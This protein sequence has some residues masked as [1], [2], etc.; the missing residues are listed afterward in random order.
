MYNY[1]VSI[2]I[3]PETIP[4]TSVSAAR[5]DIADVSQLTANFHTKKGKRGF[6][7]SG[8]NKAENQGSWLDG[9]FTFFEDSEKY[10][11]WVGTELSQ[12]DGTFLTPQTITITPAATGPIVLRFDR[13]AGEYAKLIT[14][15]ATV[16]T[17]Y[18][19]YFV[20]PEAIKDA[21]IT[22]TFTKW[23]RGNSA[24]KLLGVIGGMILTYTRNNFSKVE[25]SL[26]ITS[27]VIKFGVLAN[28][29]S[30]KVKDDGLLDSLND[31]KL[32]Q[33]GLPVKITKDDV[34]KDTFV[35]ST[36][37]GDELNSQWTIDFTDRLSYLEDE[38]FEGVNYKD[39]TL[40]EIIL[41][42]I[43]NAEFINCD[44]IDKIKI[45]NSFINTT[46]K[47][48]ALV[49]CCNVGMLYITMKN[50]IPQVRGII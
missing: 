44:Y 36:F 13:I 20:I 6:F 43:P 35:T 21:P 50:D 34:L 18:N 12:P 26:N 49:K 8:G 45:P 5:S 22:L 23:S 30:M 24:V 28:E 14:I 48:N 31:A 29:G 33:P 7:F 9:S 39:R 10:P 38:Q 4:E 17:N 47:W 16:Y 25:Y 1:K 15:G 46:T 3:N 37:S 41:L 11:G 40:K 2:E 27:D 32:L 42:I 19:Y